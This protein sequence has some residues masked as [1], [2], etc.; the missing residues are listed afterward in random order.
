MTRLRPSPPGR[1]GR[2][3][4][5]GGGGPGRDRLRPHPPPPVEAAPA[6][7]PAPLTRLC[8]ALGLFALE[9]WSLGLLA[10][11]ALVKGS[12]ERFVISDQ[13][14]APGR[15]FMLA[16][17]FAT[18]LLAGAGGAGLR[19]AHPP[20][21]GPGAP[22]AGGAAAGAGHAGRVPPVSLSVAR[23]AVARARPS[24]TPSPSSA[25]PRGR[26]ARRAV[27][28]AALGA[29]GVIG[30]RLVAGVPAW[31]RRLGALVLPVREAL[32]GR[33]WLRLPA[34]IVFVAAA[35]Y[36]VLFSVYTVTFHR[37]L[38]TAAYDLGLED[39]LVWNVLHGFGFFRSTVFSGPTGSHFGNHATFFSTSSPRSMRCRS[40]PRRCW[41]SSR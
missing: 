5:A 27:E 9:G 4:G 28:P 16:V 20:A 6:D 40:G 29:A 10:G 14:G 41:S 38:H 11:A 19:L 36:T 18:A 25:S 7:G 12:L 31:R 32:A 21:R 1:R 26:G 8:R 33:R 24:S 2:G 37:N 3:R 30:A 13:F 23:L 17:M 15:Q 35:G 39:N 34:A 22:R